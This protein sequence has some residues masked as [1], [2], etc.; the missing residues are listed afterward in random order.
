MLARLTL[1]TNGPG[2]VLVAPG[3]GPYPYGTLLTLSAQPNPGSGLVGWLGGGLAGNAPIVTLSMTTNRSVSAFFGR[4]YGPC[5][6]LVADYQ[7]PGNLGSAAGTPPPLK[8]LGT[9]HSYTNQIVDGVRQLTLRFP[10]GS[11]LILSNATSVIA[12]NT[13]TVA[14]LFKFDTTASYRRI[15]DARNGTDPGLYVNDGRMYFNPSTATSTSMVSE[16]WHQVVLTRDLAGQVGIYCD[17]GLRL[18]VNDASVGYGVINSGN[19][20]RFFKDNTALTQESGGSVARIR[21]F[22][23][24]LSAAEVAALDRLP[25]GTQFVFSGWALDPGRHFYFKISG[26]PAPL[27]RV[28]GTTD[29]QSWE[30]AS[31]FQPFAGVIWFTNQAPAQDLRL[32]RA[33]VP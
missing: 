3:P 20:L 33:V 30:T 19:T 13:Y 32:F 7:F 12:S 11:G 16:A 17:A 15:L 21:L 1:T 31:D 6:T 10:Q 2:T 28:E 8:F 23:C 9:G 25:T 22:N 26:P 18:T 4:E 27:L 5:G 24:V 29:L 14:L